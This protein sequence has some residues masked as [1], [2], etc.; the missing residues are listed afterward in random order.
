MFL[1]LFALSA[2]APKH[3][4]PA[5]ENPLLLWRVERDGKASHLLGTCHFGVDL[6]YAL[7]K[8]HDAAL[9]EASV[10]FTEA[11]LD[12]SDA[13][14][15]TG[16]LWTDGPGLSERL[17]PD[18]WR[19]VVHAVR[20]DL[21]APLLEHMEP[22][23]LSMLVPV[24]LS[25][26]GISKMGR[27]GMDQEIQRRAKARGTRVAYVE[28]IAEQA[29][30]L[31]QWND[32]FLD[33]LGAPDTDTRAD[34][35]L[36]ALCLRGDTRMADALVD[37]ADPTSEALLG[38]RN[39]AWVPK[40]LPA[41]SDG[42]AFV[43]VGAAHMF[44]DDGLLALLRAQGFTVSQLTSD[45]PVSTA[46]MPFS[47]A[48][49]EPAPPLPENF[50]AVSDSVSG[51][52]AG[53]LCADGQFLRACFE[54]D[55]ARCTERLTSDTRLCMAQWADAIPTGGAP[56]PRFNQQIATCAPSGLIVSALASGTLGDGPVCE[57]VHR[58]MQQSR[59]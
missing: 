44:G 29:A 59:P 14:Q 30:M 57:A 1:A 17:P 19:T 42:N 39:R 51:A 12:V 15:L 45:R 2:C 25:E 41:L 16:L 10:V 6:D 9:T 20:R 24:V 36:T 21:P 32:A 56:D 49:I 48:P 37:P 26:D 7:P 4:A 22:W 40:L 34:E 13:S 5:G 3:A 55:A 23:A 35:A 53:A 31:R 50:D 46:T 8:P 33:T 43:A 58:M 11:E 38:A 28:T 18:R 54:P 47:S 52:L 27:P